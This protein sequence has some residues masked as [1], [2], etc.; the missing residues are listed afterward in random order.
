[1][2]EPLIFICTCQ[3]YEHQAIFFKDTEDNQLIVTVHLSSHKNILKRLWLAIK[4]VCGYRSRFG[5][6]DE[7][8]FKPEDEIKLREYLLN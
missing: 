5:H 1:M 8:L 4:Y 6:W 2:K 7:F 3:S